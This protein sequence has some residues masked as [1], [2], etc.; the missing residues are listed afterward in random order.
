MVGQ[1][2]MGMHRVHI[3]IGMLKKALSRSFLMKYMGPARQILSMHIVWDRTNKLLWLSLE[4][5]VTKGLQRFS[6]ESARL[7]GWKSKDKVGESK[8]DE[9]TLHLGC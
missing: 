8:D 3:K 4:K 2:I 6:M 5:Y 1:V 7:V 9:G